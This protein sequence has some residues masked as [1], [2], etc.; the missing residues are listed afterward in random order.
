M[1]EQLAK[2][3]SSEFP[4]VQGFSARNLWRMRA[5][6][7]AYPKAPEFLPQ[8]VAE[9]GTEPSLPAQITLSPWGHLITLIEKVKVPVVRQWYA[10]AALEY[11]WF[12]AILVHQIE[13]RL[14]DRHGN[15]VTNFTHT[16]YRPPVLSPQATLLCRD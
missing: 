11:R 2:Y 15:A 9:T 3:L 5:F 4:G 16:L 6:Y 8:A 1:I 12:G 13:S 7:Q 10:Q 14:Y